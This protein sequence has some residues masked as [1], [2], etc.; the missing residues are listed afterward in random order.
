M[1]LRGQSSGAIASVSNVRLVSDIS[2]T[3]IGSYYIPDPT[4]L[5]SQDLKLE[6]RRLL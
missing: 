6:Q 2:A 4:M 3:L 5:V 1:T